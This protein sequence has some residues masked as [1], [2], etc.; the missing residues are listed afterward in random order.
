M[1]RDRLA[2]FE[3]WYAEDDVG[4]SGARPSYTGVPQ[5]ASMTA[6]P[7]HSAA[8]GRPTSVQ[9]EA[10]EGGGHD[11]SGFTPQPSDAPERPRFPLLLSATALR[12]AFGALGVAGAFLLMVLIFPFF[13]R[14]R[15][16]RTKGAGDRGSLSGTAEEEVEL[17]DSRS[18][19][20]SDS[21]SL[22]EREPGGQQ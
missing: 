17:L 12:V 21:D 8:P 10:E 6:A 16:R 13:G 18:P 19:F 5:R 4:A 22:V 9:V 2:A 7:V 11:G 20:D 3:A 1:L 15:C 14:A